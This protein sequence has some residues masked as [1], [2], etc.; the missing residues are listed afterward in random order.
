MAS[1]EPISTS[2]FMKERKRVV[3]ERAVKADAAF[4]A[5]CDVDEEHDGERGY[6]EP[7]YET[8]RS[9]SAKGAEQQQRHR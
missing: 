5:G 6:R 1:A 4:A 7:G 9:L 3:D 8:R 2:D